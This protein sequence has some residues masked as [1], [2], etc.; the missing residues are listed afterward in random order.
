MEGA[1][2]LGG[3]E[4]FCESLTA[5]CQQRYGRES[6]PVWPLLTLESWA[7]VLPLAPRKTMA[8][9]EEILNGEKKMFPVGL[10]SFSVWNSSKVKRVFAEL[11][12]SMVKAATDRRSALPATTLPTPITALPPTP[13]T[14]SRL[15]RLPPIFPKRQEYSSR[16]TKLGPDMSSD[17][18]QGQGCLMALTF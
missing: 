3:G 2:G 4:G 8:K 18:A 7:A 1:E 17:M 12:C 5:P 16:H 9:E 6:W 15:I 10:L 11:S 14:C 13:S